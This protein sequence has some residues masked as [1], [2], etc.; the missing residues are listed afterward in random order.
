MNNLRVASKLWG[1]F[2]ALLIAMLLIAALVLHRTNTVGDRNAEGIAASQLL[3]NKA[4]TWRGMTE[5]AV[6][7]SGRKALVGQRTRFPAADA[8]FWWLIGVDQCLH[9]VTHI[10]LAAVLA[11]A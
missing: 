3:V 9:Q 5:A 4:L 8:R 11:A 2:L 7:K 10:G 1:A 6:K